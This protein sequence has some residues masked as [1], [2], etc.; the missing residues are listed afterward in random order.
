MGSATAVRVPIMVV[1]AFGFI[2]SWFEKQKNIISVEPF[3]LVLCVF[4]RSVSMSRASARSPW[5]PRRPS[6]SLSWSRVHENAHVCH[7][8]YLAAQNRALLKSAMRR[9]SQPPHASRRACELRDRL[10]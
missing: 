9:I 5:G 1:R 2:K 7:R 8:T 6:E 10:T 3:L 4:S